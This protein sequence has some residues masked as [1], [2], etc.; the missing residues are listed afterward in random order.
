[1]MK[2]RVIALSVGGRSNRVFM[3]GEI[4]DGSKFPVNPD[5]L[6]KQGFLERVDPE[7]EVTGDQ[8]P[9]EGSEEGKKDPETEVTG[10]QKP[11]KKKNK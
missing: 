3:A 8:K 1:M 5:D 7:T 9:Y 2:Y 11:E 10:D 4:V 6:V